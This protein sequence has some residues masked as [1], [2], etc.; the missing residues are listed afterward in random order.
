MVSDSFSRNFWTILGCVLFVFSVPGMVAAQR[1]V[2]EA[3]PITWQD[4][5]ELTALHFVNPDTIWVVGE[6]GTMLHSCD[7]GQSWQQAYTTLSLSSE[8]GK[9]TPEMQRLLDS[10]RKN[11]GSDGI[12][13]RQAI[14]QC[15]D[16]RLE[17]VAFADPQ[18][19]IAVGGFFS[20]GTDI[21]RGL[22]LTTRDGGDTWEP[23]SGAVLPKL[24]QVRFEK[25]PL[26][27]AVG[28]QPLMLGTGILTTTD[29]GMNWYSDAQALAGSWRRAVRT[30]GGWLLL[31]VQGNLYV[32]SGKRLE[33]AVLLNAL[34]SRIYDV[35]LADGR[36]G[37]A[38]GDQGTFLVTHDGGHSWR[39]ALGDL[40]QVRLRS[41]DL[42]TICLQGNRLLAAGNPG[43]K[44]FV[45]DLET[46]QL[47]E[48]SIPNR[49]KLNAI[50]MAD[51]EHGC[52][53]GAQ[54]TILITR[55]GGQ[56]WQVVRGGTSSVAVLAIH[57]DE[58][59]LPLEALAKTCLA[60][61][62]RAAVAQIIWQRNCSPDRL[63]QAA[64]RLG[65]HEVRLLDVPAQRDK[66][67]AENQRMV[68]LGRLVAT[69]RDLEPRLIVSH[70]S[71]VKCPDGTTLD[72]VRLLS[73][74]MTMAADPQAFP[75]QIA[76]TG[77]RPWQAE[78][79]AVLSEFGDGTWRIDRNSLL[80]RTG[81]R[82]DDEIAIA[83]SL[84]GGALFSG[85]VITYRA[86]TLGRRGNEFHHDIWQGLAAGG[87]SIPRRPETR[88]GSRNLRDMGHSLDK[89]QAINRLLH[90]PLVTLGDKVV[91]E[92]NLQSWLLEVDR[93]TAGIWLLH[94]AESY[95]H[96]GD[97]S[98]AAM[99]LD[100][101]LSSYPDHS[102]GP[103][104]MASL[105]SYVG[106]RESQIAAYSAAQSLQTLRSII[107]DAKVSEAGSEMSVDGSVQI[108]R[109]VWTPPPMNE[110]SSS[111]TTSAD[112]GRDAKT[113]IGTVAFADVEGALW[114]S[115][116]QQFLRI[117][118]RDPELASHPVMRALEAHV[119]EHAESLDQAVNLYKQ[120]ALHPLASPLLKE[121]ANQQ[122]M[123]FSPMSARI[124]QVLC[125]LVAERP[126]LDGDLSDR[127]WQEVQAAIARL[128][129]PHPYSLPLP[130]DAQDQVWFAYD[131]EFL[132]LAITCRKIEGVVYMEPVPGRTRNP[133]LDMFDRVEISFDVDRDHRWPFRL[134]IDSRGWAA[135]HVG[136]AASWNPTWYIAARHS[137]TEWRIEAAIPWNELGGRPKPGTPWGLGLARRPPRSGDS[138]WST[139]AP[140]MQGLLEFPALT[141]HS[142]RP[143]VF[144]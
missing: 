40:D 96:K 35:V 98:A 127:T 28:H 16:V 59:D 133:I 103:L 105:L 8:Q 109:S 121:W 110:A 115:I 49:A 32:A 30:P 85:G 111:P 47:S 87:A 62:Y 123:L 71:S 77:L 4:D 122:V 21:S 3:I 117:R 54:G 42:R 50:A 107:R 29:G 23:N 116:A 112:A 113:E 13:S 53:I 68:L 76:A 84:V 128:P 125:P 66:A 86:K 132:F 72:V 60:D 141:P 70:I 101:F 18:T 41:F 143:L 142:Y 138:L 104:A 38:V 46:H 24:N 17:S 144:Q 95:Y 58:Q 20:P 26:G 5:A 34:P 139:P 134:T 114:K 15:L 67:L 37:W 69:I 25:G 82:L 99:T 36:L 33:P 126:H 45:L 94:L 91:W 19:G 74:A 6:H 130:R 11:T 83:R 137:A 120:L 93:E 140:P 89:M 55:D 57:F 31:D 136:S 81:R 73:D 106:S 90:L 88:L 131:D 80:N 61:G 14:R 78:R 43:T 48:T 102:L 65:V 118:Q 92:Q 56:R 44:I 75:E 10:V 108:S 119:V 64:S 51:S 124:P 129:T 2:G 79:L 12:S 52:A 135:D 97:L 22:V 9:I 63:V 27:W 1:R 100:Y 7:G 39:P